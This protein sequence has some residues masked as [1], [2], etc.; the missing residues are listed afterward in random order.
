[1]R[2]HS[3]GLAAS[4]ILLLL[5]AACTATQGGDERFRNDDSCPPRWYL[6]PPQDNDYIYA[7]GWSDRT[8][9]PSKS[10][11]QALTRAISMLAAQARVYIKSQMF[12]RQNL[13]GVTYSDQITESEIEGR[14]QGFTIVAEHRCFD[15][16]KHKNA[17][18]AT[19]ILIRI[20]K[21]QLVMQ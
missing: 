11:E 5:A 17:A 3:R 8:Y 2:A 16:G 20:P 15:D 19:Y 14:I 21:S 18:G 13:N 6:N 7:V 10:R 4:V 12:I 1:M 9:K